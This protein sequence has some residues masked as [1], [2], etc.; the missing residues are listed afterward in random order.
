MKYQKITIS[1]KIC[2]G[3]SSLFH[4]LEDK[5]H[6]PTFA[7]GA[8]FRQY[9]KDHHLV[10]ND[11]EEQ[12]KDLTLKVDMMVKEKLKEEGNLL[13]DAWLG[14]ILADAYPGILKVLLTCEDKV[15]FERFAKREHV[16][17]EVARTEVVQRDKSWFDKV[18]VI[19][20]RHDF[21]DPK[22]YNL[23]IDTSYLT[24]EEI[25]STVLQA[26]QDRP[27]SVQKEIGK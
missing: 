6:W 10:L 17:I 27:H 4:A 14:G 18:S 23:V 15:R 7:S 21:F 1:G 16:A 2:T 8:Y 26:L 22:N 5:L 13:L 11:A 24:Q 19:H 20:K 3:K 9:V 25:T 12:T